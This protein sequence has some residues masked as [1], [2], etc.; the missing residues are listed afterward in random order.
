[1]YHFTVFGP[2]NPDNLLRVVQAI[3]EIENQLLSITA[4]HEVHLRALMLDQLRI[5]GGEY[6]SERQ[7]YILVGGAYLTGEHL[8][9]RVAGGAEKAQADEI[10][11]LS[12]KSLL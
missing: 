3:D 11:L 9:V 5:E 4:A 10:G 1:M 12:A 7:L 6:A 8:R 2:A